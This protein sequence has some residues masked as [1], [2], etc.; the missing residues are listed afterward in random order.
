[1]NEK[2][3][4]D[5]LRP[6]WER[7][8]QDIHEMHGVMPPAIEGLREE[9]DKIREAANSTKIFTFK[10]PK[11]WWWKILHPFITGG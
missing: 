10:N 3:V 8:R 7:R 5:I 6:Y 1:M 9:F 2:E 11:P 4:N